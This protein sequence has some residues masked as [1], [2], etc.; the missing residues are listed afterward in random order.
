MVVSQ[1][2]RF[3]L[4]S[5]GV[6]IVGDALSGIPATSLATFDRQLKDDGLHGPGDNLERVKMD[7]LLEGLAVVGR[8]IERFDQG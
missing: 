6:L 4:A 2:N 5:Q 3:E 1:A 8:F 7:R